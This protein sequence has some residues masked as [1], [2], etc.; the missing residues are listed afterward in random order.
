MAARDDPERYSFTRNGIETGRPVTPAVLASWADTLKGVVRTRYLEQIG[1][2][3]GNRALAAYYARKGPALK[4]G[5]TR[6]G[7]VVDVGTL[8]TRNGRTR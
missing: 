5:L 7:K 1:V 2:T 8:D 6:K 4:P 3:A